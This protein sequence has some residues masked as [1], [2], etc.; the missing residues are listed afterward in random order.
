M[1]IFFYLTSPNQIQNL[2]FPT[3]PQIHTSTSFLELILL[4]WM[5]VWIPHWS[6]YCSA[7]LLSFPWYFVNRWACGPWGRDRGGFRVMIVSNRIWYI[8]TKACF[9]GLGFYLFLQ[10]KKS[11]EQ[12]PVN[13]IFSS[14]LTASNRAV[15]SSA[16]YLYE[17][18]DDHV[19]QLSFCILFVNIYNYFNLFLKTISIVPTLPSCSIWRN[20]G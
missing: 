5:P 2:F 14:S 7:S 16:T 6:S 12:N 1:L 3:K 10:Q 9:W 20:M 8:L 15:A 11:E 17:F 4:P 18:N 19:S 13:K